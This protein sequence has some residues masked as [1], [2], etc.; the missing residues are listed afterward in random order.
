LSS[1]REES[2]QENSN[3]VFRDKLENEF[4]SSNTPNHLLRFLRGKEEED[5]RSISPQ[6]IGREEAGLGAESARQGGGS[7]SA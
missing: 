6:L 1:K 4:D 5:V 7:D 3:S 2:I